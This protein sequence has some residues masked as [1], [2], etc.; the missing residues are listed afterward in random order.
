MYMLDATHVLTTTATQQYSKYTGS[1]QA[2]GAVIS[3]CMAS[4]VATQPTDPRLLEIPLPNA[5]VCWQFEN[6]CVAPGIDQVPILHTDQVVPVPQR[7]ACVPCPMGGF[8]VEGGLEFALSLDHSL[9][10]AAVELRGA[11]P[12]AHEVVA[13]GGV[14]LPCH[15]GNVLLALHF[16]QKAKWQTADLLQD[17]QRKFVR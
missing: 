10:P 3:G 11:T 16:K 12:F 6:L 9:H 8:L 15:L 14:A 7:L 5:V 1:S 4:K 13:V 17:A 2:H